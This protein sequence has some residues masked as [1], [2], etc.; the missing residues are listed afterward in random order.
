MLVEFVNQRLLDFDRVCAEEE[1]LMISFDEA[2]ARK[3]HHD[4]ETLVI[5]WPIIHNVTQTKILVDNGASGCEK[6]VQRWQVAVHIAEYG[7][8]HAASIAC[9]VLCNP[10]CRSSGR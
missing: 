8:D 7:H 2:N 1:P 4:L 10:A 5:P 6:C 3:R 9:L